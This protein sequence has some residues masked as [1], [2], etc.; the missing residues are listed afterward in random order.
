MTITQLSYI[1]AVDNFKNFGLAADNCFV[2]QP[3]LSMQIKKLEEELGVIVFDR[4]K[5][6]VESTEIGAKVLEQARKVL[7]ETSRITEIIEK[8]SKGMSGI[9]R[10][11][12]IPTVAPYLLPIFIKGFMKKYPDVTLIIDEI[13]TDQIIDKI[14]KDDLDAAILATP[15]NIPSII[16]K[17]LYYE[18]FV[19]FISPNSPLAGNI[20]FSALELGKI[21]KNEILLL[22]EGHC[23][24]NQVLNIC[25]R[26][27]NEEE[28]L[29]GSISFEG[30]NFETL[31]KLVKNDI[32]MTFV[33][34]L[35]AEELKKSEDNI[36]LHEFEKPVPTREISIVYPRVH[37]KKHIIDV[38]ER[39]VKRNIPGEL[40]VKDSSFVLAVN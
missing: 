30:G 12:I 39:E 2:T 18:P 20:T 6:P 32:G 36:Y 10:L 17:P 35:L 24:R 28:E 38:I 23:F 19:A 8:D 14:Q 37:L 21:R 26:D 33:P 29:S 1:V 4:T 34:Y 3:T 11:G 7:K 9:F 15:L 16:E 27:K 40:K 31:I 25:H 22:K 5:Q 13:R